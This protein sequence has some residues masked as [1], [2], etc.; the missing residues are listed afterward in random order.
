MGRD[1]VADRGDVDALSPAVPPKPASAS[2]KTPP[3]RKNRAFL[4]RGSRSITVRLEDMNSYL[5]R[6]GR[7]VADIVAEC[8]YAQ[9]R[10]FA[11]R[12]A[13]DVYL[14]ARDK[15]PGDD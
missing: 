2:G 15:A 14:A 3:S 13:P 11:L 5:A 8:N 6:F 7:R 1:L 10:M 4:R 12:T 9:R